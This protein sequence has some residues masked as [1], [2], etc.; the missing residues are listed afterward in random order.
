MS[1]F[2]W[3]HCLPSLFLLGGE[4]KMTT[5]LLVSLDKFLQSSWEDVREYS[6][7]SQQ[8]RVLLSHLLLDWEQCLF[9]RGM[10][11][12]PMRNERAE[13]VLVVSGVMTH[14]IRGK[15]YRQQKDDLLVIPACLEHTA[16]I[17]QDEECIAYAYYK[18]DNAFY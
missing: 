10:S 9:P 17:G 4:D 15:T 11:F 13:L 6:L 7:T 16:I 5:S 18:N 12:E 14:G 8:R 3:R 1:L 2:N